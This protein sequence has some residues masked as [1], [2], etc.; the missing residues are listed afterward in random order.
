MLP[1]ATRPQCTVSFRDTDL[2]VQVDRMRKPC[3][4]THYFSPNTGGISK[5]SSTSRVRSF[6]DRRSARLYHV[7]E[8]RAGRQT[9]PGSSAAPRDRPTVKVVAA[10]QAC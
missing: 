10:S 6:V 5:H 1:Q 9:R 7:T 3:R 2:F 4:I 8:V